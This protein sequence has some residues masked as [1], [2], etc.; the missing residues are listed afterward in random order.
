MYKYNSILLFLMLSAFFHPQETKAQYVIREGDEEGPIR[1]RTVVVPYAF[2]SETLGLGIGAGASYGPESQPHSTYYSTVY[3][4]DNG[5]WLG[6]I[7]G[8]NLSFK[9]FERLSFRP[10]TIF[11]Q[12]THLRVYAG[13]NNPDDLT[14][15]AGTNESSPENY[16]EADAKQAILDLQMRYTLPWGHFRDSPIHTYITKNGILKE[17]PSG[18]TSVNPLNSGQSV[19][20]FKPYY[21]KIFT[22]V[23]ELETLYFQLG[24]E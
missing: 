18:G 3:L 12:D 2:S 23:A 11:S 6:L 17:N 16:L 20:L 5:S 4:T 9:K 21:R 10:Y 7:G 19:V 1:S 24:Y 14:E 8:H 22:D 15:R 13:F